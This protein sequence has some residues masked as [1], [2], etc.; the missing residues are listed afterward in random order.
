MH[1]YS[2]IIYLF[3]AEYKSF[4]APS[5][6]NEAWELEDERKTKSTKR[7]EQWQ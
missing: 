2:F 3:G 5:A 6:K 4:I 1:F 7:N